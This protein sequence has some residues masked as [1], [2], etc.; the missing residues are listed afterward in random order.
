MLSLVKVEF[1]SLKVIK[2]YIKVLLTFCYV[3]D[4]PDATLPC[5][6]LWYHHKDATSLWYPEDSFFVI[7]LPSSRFACNKR[8]FWPVRLIQTPN[9]IK[10]KTQDTHFT[11]SLVCSLFPN[12]LAFKPSPLS[13]LWY[14]SLFV[15][16]LLFPLSPIPAFMNS[17]QSWR[18][19]SHMATGQ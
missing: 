9:I 17:R 5:I 7:S 19:G 3:D 13:P 10:M 6:R 1:R 15:C 12:M 14:P 18:F 8:I 16:H 2:S 11:F 4:L